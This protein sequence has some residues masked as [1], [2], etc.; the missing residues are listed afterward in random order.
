MRITSSLLL[1]F[2]ALA[3]CNSRK[4]ESVL[5]ML[6]SKPTYDISGFTFAIEIP[7]NWSMLE[8]SVDAIVFREDCPEEKVF[9]P[10]MVVRAMPADSLLD[11]NDVASLYMQQIEG[12]YGQMQVV[13]VHDAIIGGLDSKV[14]DYKLFGNATN[15][16]STAVFMIKGPTVV[17][18]YFSAE[19]TPEGAYLEQR[20]VFSEMLNS[21]EL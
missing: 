12:M 9:C 13:A 2:L 10:N 7:D 5:S 1:I 11:L 18:F 20:K 14:I 4:G 16:G 3:A 8:D 15:L 21:L 17:G 19:N 6:N